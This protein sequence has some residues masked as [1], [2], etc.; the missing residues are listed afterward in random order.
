MTQ[1]KPAARVP[2]HPEQRAKPSIPAAGCVAWPAWS[3]WSG[4]AAAL[5]DNLQS[6]YNPVADVR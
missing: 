6:H 1:A 2:G 4:P 3:R 5:T